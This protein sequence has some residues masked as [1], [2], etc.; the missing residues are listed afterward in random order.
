MHR[1]AAPAACLLGGCAAAAAG[2]TVAVSQSRWCWYCSPQKH[3]RILK[4]IAMQCY[5]STRL[6]QLP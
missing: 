3:S 1:E 5:G 4:A 6:S 2:I